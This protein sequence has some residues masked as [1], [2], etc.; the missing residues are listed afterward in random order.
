MDVRQIVE[1]LLDESQYDLL[2]AE[3]IFYD[4]KTT[5]ELNKAYSHGDRW[6]I[7]FTLRHALNRLMTADPSKHT[8]ENTRAALARTVSGIDDEGEIGYL[9]R[10]L[11]AG[12]A[13]MKRIIE[14]HPDAEQRKEAAK[15]L[16]WLN[17]EYSQL[18]TDRLREIKAKK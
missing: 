6:R 15:H 16:E 18:L 3:G 5:E 8:F 14:K 7:G 13:L 17:S 2:L 1:D 9:R 4:E 11:S 10:D 12:K